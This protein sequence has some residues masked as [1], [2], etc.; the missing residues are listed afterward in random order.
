MCGPGTLCD[1][2]QRRT[3]HEGRPSKANPHAPKALI[4]RL[5]AEVRNDASYVIDPAIQADTPLI[6]TDGSEVPGQTASQV[7]AASSCWR[8]LVVPGWQTDYGSAVEGVCAFIGSSKSS[9]RTYNFW[10][11]PDS[12]GTACFKVRGFWDPVV[13]PAYD[14]RPTWYTA[15]C[16]SGSSYAT[17][18]WGKVIGMPAVKGKIATVLVG[19]AGEFN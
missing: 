16:N 14:P 4:D 6:Y 17:V 9:K 5:P 1:H 3:R 2:R 13:T 11:N 12:K 8:S 18:N 15:G 7:A 10:R 19:W